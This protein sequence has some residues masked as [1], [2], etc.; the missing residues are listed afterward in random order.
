VLVVVTGYYAFQ[1]H[2][3]VQELRSARAAQVSPR[4]I[5]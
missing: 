2:L 3:T 1:T 4:S 5:A